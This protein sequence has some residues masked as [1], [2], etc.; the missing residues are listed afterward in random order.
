MGDGRGTT[1]GRG[2]LMVAMRRWRRLGAGL[3]AL[4]LGALVLTAPGC[5]QGEATRRSVD[6]A[7]AQAAQAEGVPAE[8]ARVLE[9]AAGK[10]ELRLGPASQAG[11]PTPQAGAPV[12][13]GAAEGRQVT[14]DAV[15]SLEPATGELRVAL[16]PRPAGKELY[17]LSIPGFHGTDTYTG[18]L[19]LTGAKRSSGPVDVGVDQTSGADP[20]FKAELAIS[21][22]GKVAG[23][24]GDQSAQGA[25]RCRLPDGAAPT[26]QGT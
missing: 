26:A 22:Q 10:F 17:G 13:G 8:K 2:Q 9:T 14:G 16:R 12:A 4:A 20:A 3:P 1:D 18:E 21:F 6:Q 24:A 15:C 25:A 11:A 23:S 5:G 7:K 19:G